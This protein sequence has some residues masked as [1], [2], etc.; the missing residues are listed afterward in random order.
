MVLSNSPAHIGSCPEG[1]LN[2]QCEGVGSIF[3]IE[4]DRVFNNMNIFRSKKWMVLAGIFWLSM[5][6]APYAHAVSMQMDSKM[7]TDCSQSAH[8]SMCANPLPTTASAEEFLL[9]SRDSFKPS[10][11]QKITGFSDSPY[12]PPR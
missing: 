3:G 12:H 1:E 11:F 8:C 5:V 9:P 2:L 6:F 10:S 7:M 4:S